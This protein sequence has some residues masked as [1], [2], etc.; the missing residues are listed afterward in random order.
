MFGEHNLYT[1]GLAQ[2][3]LEWGLS[4]PAT[5]QSIK[6]PVDIYSTSDKTWLQ[7]T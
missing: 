2:M 1:N 5:C 4:L 7:D 3:F 6:G